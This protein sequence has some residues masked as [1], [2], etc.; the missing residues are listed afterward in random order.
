MAEVKPPVTRPMPDI[1]AELASVGFVEAEEVGHGGFG[2]VYRCR[3]PTL[4]RTVAVKVLTT[5]RDSENLARFFREQH[6]MGRLSGHPNIVTIHQTGTLHSGQPYIVTPFYER[7]SLATRIRRSGPID[8]SHALHIAVKLAGALEAAHR[9]D[10]L[11]RDVKPGN[12]LL[13]D[14]GEPELSDFGIA[15]VAGGFGTGAGTIIA[16][17][18]FTAPEVLRGKPATVASDVYSLGAT[19]FFAI[20][21][22][23]AFERVSGEDVVA[24]FDRITEHPVPDLRKNGIPGDVAAAIEHAMAADPADRALTAAAFG[25]ELREIERRGGGVVDEMALPRECGGEPAPRHEEVIRAPSAIKL[26]SDVTSFVGRRRE[27]AETKRL[28]S[29]KRLVTLTGVGGVGKT[30]LATQVA[31]ELSGAF[32][33][34]VYLVELAHVSEPDLVPHEIAAALRIRDQ[35]TRSI[36]DVLVAYLERKHLL[37]VLDNCE[38]LVEVCG[39]LVGGMLRAAPQLTILAT[40]REPLGVL[41]EHCRI[42]P[43][44]SFPSI[45]DITSTPGRRGY[46]HEALDL[47]EERV[48]EVQPAFQLDSASMPAA[49]ELCRQ[50]DGLPLAIELAVA[51]LRALSLDQIVGRLGDRFRLLTSGNR[52]GPGRHQTLRAM[53]DWSFELCS[54]QERLLWSRLSVFVG[55]FD[56]EAIEAVCVGEDLG[57]DEII[58]VLTGLINKSIVIRDGTG[59]EVHYRMLETILAYGREHLV[60]SGDEPVFRRRHRDYYLHLAE[61]CN[62][63]WFGPDQVKWVNRLQRVQSNLWAALDSCLSPSAESAAGLRMV[64]MLCYYWNCGHEQEGRYWIDRML[65]LNKRPTR[66]RANALWVNGWIAMDQGDNVSARAYFDECIRLADQLDDQAA[67]MWAQQFLGSAEQFRGNFSRAEELLAEPTAFHKKQGVVNS[68]TL[69]GVS[70]LA[71]VLTMLGKADRAIQLCNQCRAACEPVGEQWTLSWALWV[72]GLAHWTR[73]EHRK[74]RADLT[75]ALDMKYDLN[76]QLG[77]SACVELLAWIAAEEGRSRLACQLFGAARILWSSVGGSPLFGQEVL[78]DHS[79]RYVERIRKALGVKTF[80]EEY[81]RGEHLLVQEAIA[82]ASRQSETSTGSGSSVLE[83]VGL[84]RREAEVARLVAR[85][86]TNKEIADRLF[87][88]QRTAEGHVERTLAKLGFKSRTQVAAWLSKEENGR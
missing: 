6:A 35:S 85:G 55:G 50:L 48:R 28:L 3:Q 67:R 63:T 42:V 56:L 22:H 16:S 37:L 75:A 7:D 44:L 24:Q 9:L 59:A 86:L 51:H 61:L 79:D 23:A 36:E 82:L 58:L 1:A 17:P 41:G 62:E 47:F 64:A 53:V 45:A 88:A 27:M 31:R 14:Y 29:S 38:H 12:I 4:D 34:G 73:S 5:D 33:D 68:L 87:I 77:M 57:A 70:Q 20:T 2:V 74:A 39:R 81:R 25:D 43:P 80:Y 40:S 13:T 30:R 8:L 46:G 49:A 19:L 11:H 71:F 84:T 65:C 32:G 21:G 83:E 76:D 60:A 26:V 78:I 54:A 72:S 69:V 10:V 15:H 18:A 52:G 66:E